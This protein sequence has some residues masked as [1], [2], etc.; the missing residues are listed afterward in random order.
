M[1]I[2]IYIY[3]YMYISFLMLSP[4]ISLVPSTQRSRCLMSPPDCCTWQRRSSS[5]IICLFFPL[6][7]SSDLVNA[8]SSNPSWR[9][10][11]K[12]TSQHCGHSLHVHVH[13]PDAYRSHTV[14]IFEKPMHFVPEGPGIGV[15]SLSLRFTVLQVDPLMVGEDV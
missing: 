2:C 9:K 11:K 7:A 14:R 8:H 3:I 1:F 4:C 15:K 12:K 5:F 13:H 6:C 10:V